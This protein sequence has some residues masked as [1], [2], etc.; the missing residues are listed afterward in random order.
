VKLMVTRIDG[1]RAEAETSDWPRLLSKTVDDLSR[2]ARTEMELLE[3]TLRRL[4]EA[5]TEK[6]IG[7]LFLMVVL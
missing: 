1:L 3:V 7:L 6:I 5:Q 4:T 2:I